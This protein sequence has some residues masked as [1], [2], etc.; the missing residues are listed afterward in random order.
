MGSVAVIIPA[1]LEVLNRYQSASL[2]RCSSVLKR[3]PIILVCKP[4]LDTA[5]YKKHIPGLQIEYFNK[6][7]FKNIAGYN[8]LLLSYGFYN[9][10]RNFEYILLY[11]LDAWVFRD[12][13]EDWCNQGY[14]FIGAPW[15]EGWH[16]AKPESRIIGVGNGGFS[17][18]RIQSFLNLLGKMN[19]HL[20]LGNILR[21]FMLITLF[22]RIGIVKNYID[23]F[24]KITPKGAN[25]DYHFLILS[26]VFE[27]F[28]VA[29]YDKAIRFSFD[30][31]PE[32]LYE[33]NGKKLPFGCHAWRRYNP[34]FWNQ[35]ILA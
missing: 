16:E 27:W 22:S 31:N 34:D 3:Y 1:Y 7:Y 29:P 4:D 33:M 6:E 30:V 2:I 28:K 35:F 20:L 25:E 24:N 10:F 17:L 13:L 19:Q 15:F 18:R 21:K 23:Y 12:E 14:D 5:I 9:R 8:K 32:V 26:S 11:Q